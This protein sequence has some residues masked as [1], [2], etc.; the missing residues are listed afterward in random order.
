MFKCYHILIPLMELYLFLCSLFNHEN[1]YPGYGF[2]SDRTIYTINW[3]SWRILRGF[4]WQL[5]VIRLFGEELHCFKCYS[6]VS[7]SYFYIVIN[8]VINGIMW[9]IWVRLIFPLSK[10]FSSQSNTSYALLNK[11]PR[12]I[13]WYSDRIWSR[14]KVPSVQIY[15]SKWVR[16]AKFFMTRVKNI[17]IL[18]ILLLHRRIDELEVF[19]GENKGYNFVR[20]HGQDTPK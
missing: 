17:Y 15:C 18:V 3:N 11:K 1:I 9:S 7:T 19:L 14:C 4:M 8:P 5:N 2:C 12:V 13:I 16:N 10:L 6:S 20:S